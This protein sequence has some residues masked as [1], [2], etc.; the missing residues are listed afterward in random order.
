MIVKLYDVLVV[1]L[2]HDFYLKLDLLDQVVLDNLRFVNDLD[3]I[4]VLGNFVADFVHFSEATDT[5]VGISE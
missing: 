5:D 4:D 2:V 1:E 3:S